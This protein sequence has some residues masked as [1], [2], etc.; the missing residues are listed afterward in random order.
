MKKASARKLAIVPTPEDLDNLGEIQA[1]PDEGYGDQ[2]KIVV[3]IR[4][5]IE[6]IQLKIKLGDLT[7]ELDK[8]MQELDD[9]KDL[10][11]Y[12]ESFAHH[13]HLIEGPSR[14]TRKDLRSAISKTDSNIIEKDKGINKLTEEIEELEREINGK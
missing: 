13:Y 9:A 2:E 6:Q 12:L 1:T 4:K 3:P 10:L 8:K 14:E 5:G 7:R 11:K